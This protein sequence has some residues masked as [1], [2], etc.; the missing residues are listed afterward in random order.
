MKYFS[1]GKLNLA[2]NVLLNGQLRPLVAVS[3]GEENVL[4]PLG[5]F[6]DH[7]AGLYLTAITSQYQ[8]LYHGSAVHL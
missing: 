2:L 8:A 5:G 6:V 4:H 7:S 3:Q 1:G